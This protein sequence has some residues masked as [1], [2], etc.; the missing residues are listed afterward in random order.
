MKK[1]LSILMACLILSFSFAGASFASENETATVTASEDTYT[2]TGNNGGKNFNGEYVGIASGL[3]T[4]LK[5]D[6]STLRTDMNGKDAKYTLQFTTT[7]DKTNGT[8]SLVYIYGITGIEWKES[9]LTYD[10]ANST[11]LDSDI[12]NKIG[13]ISVVGRSTPFTVDVTDYILSVPADT[14]IITIKLQNKEAT[15][16]VLLAS[17]DTTPAVPATITATRTYAETTDAVFEN[18]SVP[19]VV[20]ESIELP[21]V[22]AVYGS[23]LSWSSSHPEVIATDGTVTR[24]DRDAIV[25]LTVTNI[26]NTELTKSFEVTVPKAGTETASTVTVSED[27]F[28]RTGSNGGTVQDKNALCV[29]S[30]RTVYFK[31]D[32]TELKT[33]MS[34]KDAKYTLEFATNSD[35]TNA[36]GETVQVY[37]ITGKDWKESELTYDIAARDGLDT[38][39]ANKIA[40]ISVVGK[41]TTFTVDVTD[42]IMSVP[43]DTN[44][45]TIKLENKI[46]GAQGAVLLVSKEANSASAATLTAERTYTDDYTGGINPKMYMNGKIA[47]ELRAGVATARV[48]FVG[49][50]VTDAPKGTLILALYNGNAL[51]DIES[52]SLDFSDEFVNDMS[53]SLDVPGGEGYSVKAFLLSGF[54]TLVPLTG[55]EELR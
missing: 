9:E 2:R 20:R 16:T 54:D 10:S 33:A 13:E 28:T 38:D 42:F 39:V 35:R 5:F 48:A 47:T 3:T 12:T 6:I 21:T 45:V 55:C 40:E 31:F 50:D 51:E 30:G 14:N 49:N 52:T 26:D 1:F 4:Y 27:A 8:G 37:G 23:S 24:Q 17:K 44:I 36:T 46:D 41:D 22:G 34:G 11:G 25:T 19:S 7:A 15:G 32:I 18:I 43:T 53:V 29:S